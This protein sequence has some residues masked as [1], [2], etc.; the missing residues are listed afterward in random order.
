MEEAQPKVLSQ[1]H[2]S[3]STTACVLNITAKHWNCV[4]DF[5]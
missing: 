3:M 1:K 2:R 4:Y 5:M